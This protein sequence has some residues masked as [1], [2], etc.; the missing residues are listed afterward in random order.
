MPKPISHR[1]RA[2]AFTLVEL[3]V[4][5]GIIAVLISVLLPVLGRARESS[6]RIACMS[7]MHQ[8][9]LGW[10]MYA[11]DNKGK[12]VSSETGDN[13]WSGDGNREVDI[14]KGALFKY[15]KNIKLYWC[16]TDI[17]PKN[18]RTYS[19]N[20]A[21]NGSWGSIPAHKNLAQVRRTSES[22]VFIEEFDPRGSNLGSFVLY[23]KGDQWV[24]Y[25]VSWHNKGTCLSMAD[26]HAE[27][28][29]WVDTRTITMHDF[30]Q[31]TPNNPDLKRLQK[32][33][34]Y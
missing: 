2:R 9:T 25:V 23:N 11:H 12:L 17:A 18:I 14:R 30:Y 32:V 29:K 16:P 28:Y 33:A 34:G 27:Y 6:Q 19:M 31:V 4:V 26:G 15:V 3:L 13:A 22:F 1:R 20:A 24:D 21:M 7:N 8:L 5:I 10:L